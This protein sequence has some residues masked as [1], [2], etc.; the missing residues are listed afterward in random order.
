MGIGKR[1]YCGNGF[2]T[3]IHKVECSNELVQ[4]Q[5]IRDVPTHS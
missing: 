5:L 2:M 3:A 1:E 4:A